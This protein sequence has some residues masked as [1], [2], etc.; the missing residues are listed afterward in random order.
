[1]LCVGLVLQARD[2]HI[3]QSNIEPV[4]YYHIGV[5]RYMVAYRKRTKEEPK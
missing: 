2:E 5:P 4:Y 1:M 3:S